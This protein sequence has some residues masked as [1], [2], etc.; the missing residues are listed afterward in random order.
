MSKTPFKM[1]PRTDP[2]AA[3]LDQWVAGGETAVAGSE[4]TPRI[5]RP[6]GKVARLTID[7]TPE[8]H[9]KFKATCAIKGTRM[10]DEVRR[11]IE[12]WTQK[13]S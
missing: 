11:F 7:L 2:A 3:K 1:P 12:G 13:N 6:A 4:A 5:E 9:A 8:L 10:I